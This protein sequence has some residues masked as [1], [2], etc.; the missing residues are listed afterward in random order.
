MP[1]S[2]PETQ[3]VLTGVTVNQDSGNPTILTVT[4]L[5]WY[6]PGMGSTSINVNQRAE[7]VHVSTNLAF[8]ACYAAGQCDHSLYGGIIE[9]EFDG[10]L[11]G[12][13][14]IV[15]TVNFPE[16]GQTCTKSGGITTD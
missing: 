11:E 10:A 15:V 5:N 4:K 1:I 12:G 6:H 2:G 7:S 9:A 14:D 13:Y 8:Y 16:F 3:V